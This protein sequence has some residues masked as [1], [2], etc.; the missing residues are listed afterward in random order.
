MA[1]KRMITKR[2]NGVFQKN[3]GGKH[4]KNHN[5]MMEQDI[6]T[7]FRQACISNDLPRSIAYAPA[8]TLDLSNMLS[9]NQQK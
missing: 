7:K 3:V 6:Q 9:S 8:P 5:K 4:K 2:P 1:L